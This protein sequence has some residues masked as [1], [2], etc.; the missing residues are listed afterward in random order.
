M[1]VRDQVKAYLERQLGPIAQETTARD[2]VGQRNAPFTVATFIGQPVEGAFT[3]VTL[4]LSDRPLRAPSSERVRQELLVCGWEG[5]RKDRVYEAL[6]TVAQSL[7]DQDETANPGAVLKLHQP[8]ADEGGLEHVFLFEPVYFP[9]ALT[10]VPLERNSG[11]PG[12]QAVELI[13]LVPITAAEAE[14]AATQGPESFERYL[15]E[16]DPDLLDLTRSVAD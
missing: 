9:E 4:G 8:L 11:G 2:V 3:L 12:E 16:K 7:R 5:F 14:L 15:G 10:E 6:F 1:S 13:W